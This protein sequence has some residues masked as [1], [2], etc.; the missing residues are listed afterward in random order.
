ML[1]VKVRYVNGQPIAEA[2]GV[3]TKDAKKKEPEKKEP[4]KSSKKKEK[5][6]A[7]LVPWSHCDR[8]SKKRSAPEPAQ[9]TSLSKRRKKKDDKEAVPQEKPKPKKP[10]K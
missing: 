6:P 4:K 2:G 7:Y 8:Q 3:S 10:T 5:K 1:K 9:P